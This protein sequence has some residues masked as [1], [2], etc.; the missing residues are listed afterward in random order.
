[1]FADRDTS[2]VN[3]SVHPQGW[4]FK[5]NQH[6]VR[7]TVPNYISSFTEPNLNQFSPIEYSDLEI[8]PNVM[9]NSNESTKSK[10]G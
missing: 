2:V 10:S 1:M 9:K 4:T 5:V 7:C 6:D 8:E 3:T